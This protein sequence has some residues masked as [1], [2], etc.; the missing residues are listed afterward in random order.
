L[1]AVRESYDVARG[2]IVE[3]L[4]RLVGDL[5]GRRRG[6]LTAPGSMNRFFASGPVVGAS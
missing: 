1:P 4:Q 5:S 3:R 6:D 2:S